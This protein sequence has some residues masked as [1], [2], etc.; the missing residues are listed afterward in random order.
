MSSIFLVGMIEREKEKRRSGG[1]GKA[2]KL[3][4]EL[5]ITA[6]LSQTFDCSKK[7]MLY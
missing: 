5:W 3:A 4:R 6:S 1:G 2:T 7:E